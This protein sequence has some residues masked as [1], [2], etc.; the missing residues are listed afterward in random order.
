M[1][2]YEMTE[3]LTDTIA[4]AESLL[5]YRDDSKS[6][7][8]MLFNNVE[9]REFV[10]PGEVYKF[11]LV[12]DYLNKT[13]DIAIRGTGGKKRIDRVKS[14][15]RY[16]LNFL[17]GKDGHHD[18]FQKLASTIVKTVAHDLAELYKRGYSIGVI[19]GH[20]QGGST[21]PHV[22]MMLLQSQVVNHVNVVQFAPA[23]SSDSSG[24]KEVRKYIY[25]KKM[26]CRLYITESEPLATKALRRKRSVL[27]DGRYPVEPIEMPDSIPHKLG[28]AEMVNHSGHQYKI[29][30]MRY[31]HEVV[32]H[33]WSHDDYLFLM[34][35]TPLIVN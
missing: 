9:V 2:K 8:E 10:G 35:I 30:F 20:S 22:G 17:T 6:V 15:F 12:V 16:N 7:I 23:P 3:L 19:D 5:I 25:D 29:A 31:L 11:A 1:N 32:K 13:V 33:H 34:D 18:G 21:A 27:F 26:S 14:W 28:P 24:I 4:L